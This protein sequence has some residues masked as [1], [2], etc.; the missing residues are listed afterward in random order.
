M[1]QN[2]PS[3]SAIRSRNKE[4][5][6]L[7]YG[8]VPPHNKEAE[9]AVLGQILV[10]SEMLTEVMAVLP[11][12]DWFYINHHQLV[13]EAIL[14]AHHKGYKV[15]A[16]VVVSELRAMDKLE[17]VGGAYEVIQLTNGFAYYQSIIDH[18]KLIAES[19][20]RREAI[21]ISCDLLSKSYD[22]TEDVNETIHSSE[23]ALVD[24]LSVGDVSNAVSLKE[25]IIP[26]NEALNKAMQSEG[27]L[28]G[29]DTGFGYL[30][31][32][33]NGWQ[34]GDLIILAARPS[35]GK[36]AFSL[37]LALNACMSGKAQTPV[38]IFSLE[39]P[40][41]KLMNRMVSSVSGIYL[42]KIQKGELSDIE[43]QHI[44]S[45]LNRI[46]NFPLYIDD[47]FS[48]SITQLKGRAKRL[49]RERD[50]GFLI[51]DYLQLM[52]GAEKTGN[53]EQ[54]IASISRGLK[55]IAMELGI[56]VI[57]LSQMSRDIEKNGSKREP[58][59]SDLRESGA[60]EQDADMVM[61][62]YHEVDADT[63]V[64]KNIVRIAK[65]RNGEL[66]K[67]D[68]CKFFPE[69]Q[70]WMNPSEAETY[71][72]TSGNKPFIRITTD[73]DI[74][75]EGKSNLKAFDEKDTPF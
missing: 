68:Q 26:F 3:N 41:T 50:I 52:K 11:S 40:K 69:I 61:F 53:R 14:S 48:L 19:H 36:T 5:L 55:G 9:K 43:F 24:V 65:H 63:G 31:A 51:V 8:K 10:N 21:R 29:V 70:K 64:V 6:P 30:N 59:L 45:T 74:R 16:V 13:Y 28:T 34:P 47:T 33:T 67:M 75:I 39:M 27:Q 32:I 60:I 25:C 71:S 23:K 42:D 17:T 72:N 73:P 12:P 35:V 57:A 7:L 58:M 22:E 46:V 15:D 2:K 18:A 37:N 38:A 62:I 1:N 4:S 20:K 56:P 44:Q 66:G 49:K 54:E